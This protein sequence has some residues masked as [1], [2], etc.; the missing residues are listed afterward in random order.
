MSII[1]R[2]EEVAILRQML[3]SGVPEF[4]ALYGRRRVG[5][6]F[7]IRQFFATQKNVVFF[8]V[9]GAKD[10]LFHEQIGHFSEQIG[11]VFLNGVIPKAGKNWDETFG[12]LTKTF[13]AFPKN[14]KIVLFFDELPWMATKRSR[15]LQNLDYYWNQH[16]SNDNRIK[17]IVCGS[18]ASWILNKIIRNRG[19]LYNRITRRIYLEPF[20]LLETKMFLRRMGVNLNDK[21]I[22]LLYMAI[23]GIPYY[24]RNV[25]KGLTAMQLIEKMAFSKKAFLLDEFD[26]LFSS[27]FDDG[28]I[29]ADIVRKISQYH[30]GIGQ[31]QLLESLGTHALGGVGAKKLKDLEE[32]GFI[33]S[34][35]PL[36]HKKK[37]I[38]YRINDEYTLFYL[39]WI[40]P[41]HESL[42]KQALSKGNWQELQNT[43]EW[44]NWL[45]YAFETIC[46]KHLST[47]RKK[48]D[49]NPTAIANTWRYA[50]KKGANERGAQVDLLFDR[51]DNAIT[52]CEI[53]YTE[54]PFVLTKDYVDTLKRK[55]DVFQKQTKT[56]KQLFIAIISAMGLKNN[57]YADDICSGVVTMGDL[58][59][60]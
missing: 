38:Y 1:S 12:L 36:Y 50:P 11:M 5:K 19:G 6:T 22:L 10:G 13:K 51:R 15:L 20:N 2:K 17:L 58:F 7:L 18:S 45:G 24:L 4:L 47:I 54:E 28:D 14:K 55:M 26:N 9:T 52:L 59:G 31:R 34:F 16:W 32:T 49:I 43:P 41:I 42:Q 35:K 30:Y 8:N 60:E 37:G 40:E 53:K 21:Q 33:I 48:L 44:N 57:Y 25:D 3:N 27:L 56:K 23:G 46:Y 39:K 29:Y